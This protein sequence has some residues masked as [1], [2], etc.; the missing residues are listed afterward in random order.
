MTDSIAP[1]FT[2]DRG[3]TEHIT[4]APGQDFALRPADSRIVMRWTGDERR[5]E[6]WTGKRY[7]NLEALIQ[8]LEK[9]EG[10]Y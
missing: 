2:L 6:I 5:C 8:R 3:I 4:L 10:D 1:K 7:I 9:L